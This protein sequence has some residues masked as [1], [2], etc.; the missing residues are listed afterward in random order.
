M[1]F[2]FNIIHLTI[3]N[4]KD[5]NT[6]MTFKLKAKLQYFFCFNSKYDL[7]I[8]IYNIN[9]NTSPPK[10]RHHYQK[11][12]SKYFFFGKNINPNAAVNCS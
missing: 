10:K 2:L 11:K 3:L 12:K 8:K 5:P 9:S 4:K 1:L 6:F 7:I